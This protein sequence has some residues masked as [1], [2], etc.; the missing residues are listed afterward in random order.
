MGLAGVAAATMGVRGVFVLSG[1]ICFA[2]GLLAVWLFRG[3]AVV[4][5]AEPGLAE[6]V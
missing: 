6:S 2:G 5:Q 4:D 1:V 3:L